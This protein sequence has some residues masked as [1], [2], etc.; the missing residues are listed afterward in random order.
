V[1][2]RAARQPAALPCSRRSFFVARRKV[3]GRATPGANLITDAAVEGFIQSGSARYS[4]VIKLSVHLYR[5]AKFCGT[6]SL[7]RRI[8]KISIESLHGPLQ[9]TGR[10]NVPW[11][12]TQKGLVATAPLE[13]AGIEVA[14]NPRRL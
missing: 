4:V 11:F 14:L 3:G 8:R 6:S 10:Q 7:I 1:F 12:E 13:L 9:G 5:V 2:D